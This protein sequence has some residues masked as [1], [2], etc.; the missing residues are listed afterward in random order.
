MN[1][2]LLWFYVSLKAK[3]SPI[4]DFICCGVPVRGAL[5]LSHWHS[6]VGCP[7]PFLIA[8]Y[9]P[10]VATRYPLAAG[11]TVSEHPNY[12]LRVWLKPFMFCSAVK[13]YNHLAT[14]LLC[15]ITKIKNSFCRPLYTIKFEQFKM[16][17]WVW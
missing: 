8:F 16:K 10:S 12:D 3:M 1:Q 6:E 5:I 11:W 14:R 2:P 13:C 9:F 17:S 15:I 7:A 4:Y